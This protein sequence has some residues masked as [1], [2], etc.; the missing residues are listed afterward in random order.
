MDYRI[1]KQ[2]V[3]LGRGLFLPGYAVISGNRVVEFFK[4]LD[5]ARHYVARKI[6]EETR[7]G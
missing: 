7:D 2:S 5:Q 1:E 6:D 3:A 4:Y